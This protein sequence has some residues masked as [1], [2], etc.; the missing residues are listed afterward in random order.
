MNKNSKLNFQGKFHDKLR[1]KE[2]FIND[3]IEQHEEA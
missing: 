2:I 3:K 1:G